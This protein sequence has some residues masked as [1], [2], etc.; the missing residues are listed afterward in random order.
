M[1]RLAIL[2]FSSLFLLQT[3]S[4]S[5][6]MTL[7]KGIFKYD[8]T[9]TRYNIDEAAVNPDNSNGNWSTKQLDEVVMG[10]IP[11]FSQ[12]VG[13]GIP[14]DLNTKLAEEWQNSFYDFQFA[15]GITNK[16]TVFGTIGYDTSYITATD[17]YIQ[18]TKIIDTALTGL[19]QEYHYAPKKLKAD[20]LSLALPT[21]IT[22]IDQYIH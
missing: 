5:Q 12:L 19:G 8:F 4:F 21:N 3:Q 2:I 11:M 20:H 18:Q 6:S 15:Y 13:L 22:K 10:D 16:L 9:H 1:N 14:I 7:P 17:E